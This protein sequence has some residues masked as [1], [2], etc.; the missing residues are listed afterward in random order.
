MFSRRAGFTMVELVIAILIGSI[1]TS[2]ALASFRNVT[3]R[4]AARGAKETFVALHARTRATAIESGQAVSLIVNSTGDSVYISRND[5]ILELIRFSEE[6]NVDVRSD[7][8]R[9]VLCIGPQGFGD[10]DCTTIEE[11]R[12]VQFWHNA[13][14]T[15]LIVMPLGQLVGL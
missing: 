9:F 10:E 6:L 5:T 11:P 12:R 15:S 3:G 7:P 13:D 14:S 2:I 1:L 8:N 4:F